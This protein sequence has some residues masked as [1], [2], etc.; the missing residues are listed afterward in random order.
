[1][2]DAQAVIQIGA[3][4]AGAHHR[5]DVAIGRRHDAHIHLLLTYAAQTAQPLFFEQ[6]QQLDLHRDINLADFVEE[7][8]AALGRL[9]Q[10]RLALFGIGKRTAFIAEELGLEQIGGYRRAVNLDKGPRRAHTGKMQGARH[11]LF[12][13]AGLARDEYG[14]CVV[15]G[16]AALCRNNLL[17]LGFE[18]PHWLGIADQGRQPA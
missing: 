12:A 16:Q 11:Q 10:A 9:D 18:F 3:K 8:R 6:F 2:H 1:M 7:Q 13:G 15:I 4:R 17:H 14:G 5:L